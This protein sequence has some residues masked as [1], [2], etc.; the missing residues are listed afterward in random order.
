MCHSS[1]FRDAGGIDVVI[2]NTANPFHGFAFGNH[3][4]DTVIGL[5]GFHADLKRVQHHGMVVRMDHSQHGR[6]INGPFM[7]RHLEKFE[8]V[9]CEVEQSV[10]E[11]DAPKATG[12]K[13]F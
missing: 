8:H 1:D 2:T 6:K 3:P 9:F 11:G 7:G 12:E 10:I 5:S 4:V 13:S